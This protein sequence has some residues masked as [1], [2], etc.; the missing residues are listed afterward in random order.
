ME[1]LRVIGYIGQPGLH[2]STSK[3]SIFA[4]NIYGIELPSKV[5]F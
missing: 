3:L 2:K 5:G 4:L 1:T